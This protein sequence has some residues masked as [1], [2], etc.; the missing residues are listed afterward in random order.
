MKFIIIIYKLDL[1]KEFYNKQVKNMTSENQ[2]DTSLI[3]NDLQNDVQ[4]EELLEIL[5]ENPFSSIVD[6]D[7]EEFKDLEVKY[8]FHQEQNKYRNDQFEFWLF[9][10]DSRY[11]ND[12]AR[13]IP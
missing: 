11:V 8:V 12:V 1:T 5:R 10:V 3:V 6:L 7:D 4:I 13:V 9:E 2:V